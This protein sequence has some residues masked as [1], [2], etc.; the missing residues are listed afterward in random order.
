MKA[1]AIIRNAGSHGFTLAELLVIIGIIAVIATVSLPVYRS[2]SM[3]INL[4][5]AGRDMATDLRFAQQQAVTTQAGYRVAFYIGSNSYAI[6]NV[7]TGATAKSRT[8]KAPITIVSVTG[9]TGDAV[10]FNA[11]GAVDS[12]GIITLAN[13][14]GRRIA[15]DIKPSGYVKVQ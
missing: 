6:I 12:A 4:T 1:A 15:I 10:T 13:P 8:L 11:T 9:L 2:I 5:S 14:N 7:E 3:N